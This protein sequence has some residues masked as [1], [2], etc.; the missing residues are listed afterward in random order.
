MPKH[1][2][3]LIILLAAVV[4]VAFAARYLLV[5]SSYYRYGHYRGDAV[6]EIARDTPLYKGARSC[7][8]CHRRIFDQWSAS[9]HRVQCEDCH[10]PAGGH[11]RVGAPPLGAD[12][13]THQVLMHSRYR[14]ASGRM[15][16]PTDTA[17]LCLQCHASIVGRPAAQLQ[18][19]ASEHA[20]TQQCAA[21]HDVHSP[22]IVF[23]PVPKAA[24]TGSAA[25]AGAASAPCAG[26]HGAN[27]ISV[28]PLWPNLAGQQRAYLVR[29]LQSYRTG[30]RKAAPMSMM[31]AG[32]NDAEIANLA[33]YFSHLAGQTSAQP[34]RNDPALVHLVSARAC[35]TCH[36]RNGLSVNPTVPDLAG[37]KQAYL[38]GALDA[39]RSGSRQDAL[40]SRVARGLTD[41][42]VSQLSLYYSKLQCVGAACKAAP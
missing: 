23:P 26:C 5:P 24:S 6:A 22:K 12:R 16:V 40:M 37:Q 29:A 14:V 11:P 38:A 30:A 15:Q 17:H 42:D 32:L 18:V 20:G 35:A 4:T 27:G 19:S 13:D 8:A 3:R 2:A 36:G 7:Q 1:I 31:A 25:G 34:Q 10:G 21:C 33:A 28:S 41:D 9:A 39:Y